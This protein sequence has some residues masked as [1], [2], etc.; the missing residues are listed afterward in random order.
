M[1][2]GRL[3]DRSSEH[4]AARE[5]Q[6]LSQPALQHPLDVGATSLGETRGFSYKAAVSAEGYTH[7]SPKCV[8]LIPDKGVYVIKWQLGLD[9]PSQTAVKWNSRNLRKP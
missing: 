7:R 9:T 8:T 1:L 4:L 6:V 3:P 2:Q 5:R